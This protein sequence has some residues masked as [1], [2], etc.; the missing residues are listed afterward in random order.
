MDY[1]VSLDLNGVLLNPRPFEQAHQKWFE[2]FSLVLKDPVIK[3]Y[4]SLDNY[5]DKVHEIM[6]LY[7]GDVSEE[8]LNLHARNLYSTMVVAEASGKDVVKGMPELLRSTKDQRPDVNFAIITSSPDGTAQSLLEKVNCLDLFH[9]IYESPPSDVPN[10]SAVL[11]SFVD[12]FGVPQLY[13]GAGNQDL[14]LYERLGCQT[15]SCGFTNK[16]K[17][18]GNFHASTVNDLKSLLYSPDVDPIEL[19]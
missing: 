5:F 6:R 3:D 9:F 7:I 13:I 1:I 8:S 4:A 14:D 16:N 10:K 15:I 11:K 17:R 18:K 12:E 2:F 19:N